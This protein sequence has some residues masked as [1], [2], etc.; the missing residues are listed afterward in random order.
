MMAISM[1]N[2]GNVFKHLK[3]YELAVTSFQNA[4]RLAEEIG[5]KNNMAM[6]YSNMS[7]A[8]VEKGDLQAAQ[9]SGVKSLD[10]ARKQENDLQIIQSSA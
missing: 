5:D 3:K 9:S 8:Y 10:L 7:D 6:Y 2:L 1:S 4:I